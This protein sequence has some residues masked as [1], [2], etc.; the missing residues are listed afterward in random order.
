MLRHD[1]NI[2]P[3][4]KG[5]QYAFPTKVRCE[6]RACWS[7]RTVAYCTQG[8]VQYRRCLVCGVRFKVVGT[9]V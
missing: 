7:L 5:A 3:E 6:N 4:R 8:H 1:D 9:A 2:D